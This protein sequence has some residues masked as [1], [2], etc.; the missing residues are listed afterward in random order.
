MG[1]RNNQ[2]KVGLSDGI[3][4]GGGAQGDHDG[5]GR[6]HIVSAVE[7]GGKKIYKTKLIAALGG[8]QSTIAHNNQPTLR[9]SN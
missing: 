6:C 2:P 1:G 7:F 5:G 4:R 9:Q 8:R 3:V